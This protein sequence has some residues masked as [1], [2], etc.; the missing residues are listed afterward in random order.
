MASKLLVNE[1]QAATGTDITITAGHSLHAAA[2]VFK[3]AGGIAG[4]ALV[5]DGAGNIS[6]GT[7][8]LPAQTSN[9][10]KFLTTDGTDASWATVD[11]LPSQTGQAGEFLQTDGTTATWEAVDA[12]PSQTGQAG[13]YL[14]TDGTTAT[15]EAVTSATATAVSDQANTSTGY[16]DVPAGTTAQRP[17]SP[18]TGNLRLNTDLSQLEHYYDNIWIGFA[19]SVPTITGITPT[20]SIAAGTVITVV[21]INFQAGIT[22]KLIGT[23]TSQYNA[24]SVTFVSNTEI[25][26]STPELP[27]ALEPFDVELTLPNGGVAISTD[28]IDAGGVPAWTTA[29]GLLGQIGMFTTGTHFTLVATDPDGQA[30]TYSADTANT[31]I[32]T[33]AGLT[34]NSDGT[35][36]GDP[37]DVGSL[38]TYNFDAIATDSTGVNSTT[39]SFS[40]AVD[41]PEGN[42]EYTT[43]GSYTWTVPA[44]L[45]GVSVHV[46]CVGGGGASGVSNSGQ[47]GG[48]GALVYRNTIA[49][50]P[51]Q[52]ANIV[53]GAGGVRN[54]SG[55]GTNGLAG[56]NSS[57]TYAGTA[58][59]AGGGG[60]G[61]A[62]DGSPGGPGGTKQGTFDGGGTGGQ[63]GRDP[64]NHGGPGGGGAG[65]YSGNG[66]AGANPSGSGST[67]NGSAGSGGGG[68]G[69]GKGGTNEFG[70]GGG[71]GVGIYGTGNSGPG[72][73]GVGTDAGGG[74]GGA[75]SNGG[76]GQ[77]GLVGGHGGIGGVYGGGWGGTQSSA[78]NGNAGGGAVRIIWGRTASFP[79]DAAQV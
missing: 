8:G 43:A 28:V 65:G 13:E 14:Q 40:I 12:L 20:L 35:I 57:F 32:L 41:Y 60:G 31:A 23:D 24:Q 59:T 71:G 11:A 36:T 1:L 4:Q 44:D 55:D 50:V 51:G 3:I 17:G 48:G 5:T 39:R 37:T 7:V 34:L 54:G 70:G 16:F 53:V 62:A 68:G 52:T 77:D 29:A 75:G 33:S 67:E 47:G 58:T 18:A 76:V 63:G 74:G 25:Q 26:F 38:T 9:S 15:W 49:V 45:V 2:S 73:Q 30:V 10:G 19:G 22:V 61:P 42:Q 56:G 66:G 64:A 46:V 79:S 78:E 21:G 6:F 69:G 72:G 27:A